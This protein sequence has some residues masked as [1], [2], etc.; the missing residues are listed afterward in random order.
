MNKNKKNHVVAVICL[1]AFCSVSIAEAGGI[2]FKN[3]PYADDPET[4]TENQSQ[5]G[6][7][8]SFLNFNSEKILFVESEAY[9]SNSIAYLHKEERRESGI[10]MKDDPKSLAEIKLTIAR[11]KRHRTLGVIILSV[12][13]PLLALGLYAFISTS[14]SKDGGQQ[15][16]G[17]S[18]AIVTGIPG[19]IIFGSGLSI[20]RKAN[21]RI[22]QYKINNKNLLL[23]FSYQQ[24]DSVFNA[25]LRYIF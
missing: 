9:A 12:G 8:K 4:F 23:T 19:L 1:F 21:T 25:G 24:A 22:S 13:V 16:A 15:A 5:N 18:V 14:G 7:E 20:I 2:A 17:L 6:P 3:I 10:L 11:E